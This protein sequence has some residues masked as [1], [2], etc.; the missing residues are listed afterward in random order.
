VNSR[1]VCALCLLF[2]SVA[3]AHDGGTLGPTTPNL[4]LVAGLA[5]A[6]LWYARGA[7]SIG[8]ARKL[9]NAAFALAIATLLL[10]LVGP[11][12]RL[13]DYSFAAHMT[14]HELLMLLA[15][16]LLVLARPLPAYL[17]ALPDEPRGRAASWLRKPGLVATFRWLSAPALTLLVH[18]MVRWLWHVPSLFEAAMNDEWVHGLQHASFFATAAL[19]WWG[20]VQ[21]RYGRAGYGMAFVF[22][23][24]TAMHTGAL[25]ALLSFSEHGWYPSYQQR[26]GEHGIDVV[27]DQQLAGLIMWV[28]AGLWMMLLALALFIAWLGEAR[29][30]V[31]RGSVATLTRQRGQPC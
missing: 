19:F 6:S 18:G 9:E 15:A 11:L 13:S 31:R 28:G 25:G 21:G 3:R 7:F 4:W 16:P 14:Q 8:R 27:L 20:M 22:V 29:S 2:T 23:L 17:R 26:T 24:L 12:D 10:A 30:R 1:F 5:V